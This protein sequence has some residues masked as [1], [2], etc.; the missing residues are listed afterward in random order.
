M[1]LEYENSSLTK[2]LNYMQAKLTPHFIF[3]PAH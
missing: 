1:K 3:V 2:E